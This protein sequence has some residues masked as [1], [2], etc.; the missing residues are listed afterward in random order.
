MKVDSYLQRNQRGHEDNPRVFREEIATLR[1]P[2]EGQE[3]RAIGIH[4]PYDDDEQD[5]TSDE[6][7]NEEPSKCNITKSGM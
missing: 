5:M 6:P 2:I 3:P 1:V 4:G 7:G